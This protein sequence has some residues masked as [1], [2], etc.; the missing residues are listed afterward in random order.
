[1]QEALKLNKEALSAL[2]M[3]NVTVFAYNYGDRKSVV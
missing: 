1:M 3:A 2:I